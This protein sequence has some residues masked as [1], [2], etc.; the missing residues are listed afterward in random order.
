MGGLKNSARGFGLAAASLGLTLSCLAGG[1]ASAAPVAPPVPSEPLAPAPP[2]PTFPEG[3]TPPEMAPMH[4]ITC[5]YQASGPFKTNPGNS[6]PIGFGM[7]VSCNDSPDLRGVTTRLWRYDFNRQEYFIHSERYSNETSANQALTYYASCSSVGVE[8]AFHTEVIG[9]AF[10]GNWDD[11][12]RDN[13]DSVI[14]R[15]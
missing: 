14:A 2:R 6:A 5:F 4:L 10:H 7:S 1:V 11:E 8:Y 13:S 12:S 9:N 15:C 3:Y